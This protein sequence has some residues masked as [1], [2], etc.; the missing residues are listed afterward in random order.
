MFLHPSLILFQTHD[1][2][3]CTFL[4]TFSRL[5][6]QNTSN[7][8]WFTLVSSSFSNSW[9][10][11]L[12]VFNN[13]CPIILSKH[14][15]QFMIY[16]CVKL[17]LE[18]IFKDI[19]IDRRLPSNFKTASSEYYLFSEDRNMYMIKNRKMSCKNNSTQ[20]SFTSW[21]CS[22]FYEIQKTIKVLWAMW[23]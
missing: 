15:Q 12:Y 10:K 16:T 11:L 6:F 21:M 14:F 5:F 1:S 7:S 4:I 8:L 13:F 23:Y 19:C 20:T 2:N 17:H 22:K 9:F 18:A 3:C